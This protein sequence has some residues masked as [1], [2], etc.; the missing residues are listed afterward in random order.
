MGTTMMHGHPVF[1]VKR[2]ERATRL[3]GKSPRTWA[4][5]KY[6]KME[7]ERKKVTAFGGVFEGKDGE[8]GKKRERE[9]E[10]EK[11]RRGGREEGREGEAAELRSPL[12]NL[13][14]QVYGQSF[15]LWS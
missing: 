7:G 3:C 15:S 4:G 5:R 6:R 2:A 1:K 9:R 10:E 8:R 13:D 12:P 11:Q 14:D